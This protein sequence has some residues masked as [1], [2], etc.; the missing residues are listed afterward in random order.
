MAR[1]PRIDLAGFHHVVNRGVERR[2]VFIDKEDYQTFLTLLCQLSKKYEVDV[3]SYCLMNN[4]YHLLIETHQENLSKFMRAINA[5]YAAMFNRKYKRVGHL[6]QG[7]FK[8]WFVT[9]E[10]YLYTL[11]KYI[12]YNPLKAKMIDTLS[13]YL[14]SSYNAFVHN[15]EAI[16]CLKASVMFT[17][18]LNVDERAEFFDSWYDEDVLKE[19][20]KASKLVISSVTQKELSHEE[21]QILFLTYENKTVRNE[22]ILKAVELGY[23]QNDIAKVLKMTQGMISH[24]LRKSKENN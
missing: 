22:K 23:S 8:S 24:V 4:H 18:F 5:Q 6:W 21:L 19:I 13:Q 3:H 10:A 20:K 11:I 14:Y 16:S 12:E 9:D 1:L 7:R 2:E 15:S 17:Q